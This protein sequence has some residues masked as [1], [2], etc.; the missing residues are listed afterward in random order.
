MM[1]ETMSD[2]EQSCC[3][4]VASF[5]TMFSPKL[6]CCRHHCGPLRDWAYFPRLPCSYPPRSEYKHIHPAWSRTKWGI[7][8]DRETLYTQ[9]PTGVDNVAHRLPTDNCHRLDIHKKSLSRTITATVWSMHGPLSTWPHT[10]GNAMVGPNRP[11]KW[12][13]GNT[14]KSQSSQSSKDQKENLY[15]V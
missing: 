3:L 6:V 8:R 2:S 1:L 12:S 9:F 11:S 5:S 15:A 4:G 10:L 14:W 7:R 13:N